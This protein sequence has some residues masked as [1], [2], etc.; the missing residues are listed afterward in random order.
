MQDIGNPVEMLMNSQVGPYVFPIPDEFSNWRDEQ[1]SWRKTAVLFDQS[2]H[3][4]DLYLK[5]PDTFRLLSNLGVNSFKSF[6]R[7][8]AKQFVAVNYD[9]FV[10][11]DAIL[12]G[13]EDR[14]M[15]LLAGMKLESENRNEPTDVES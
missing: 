7:N 6:R 13:L 9:G 10:N 3:M 11:G 1:E 12:F 15:A 2:Y 4:L 14:T 8:L 5:E